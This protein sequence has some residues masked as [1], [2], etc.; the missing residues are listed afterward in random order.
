M[1]FPVNSRD[2]LQEQCVVK[3]EPFKCLVTWKAFKYPSSGFR[4]QVFYTLC[5]FGQ[6]IHLRLIENQYFVV[7]KASEHMKPSAMVHPHRC[8]PTYCLVRPPLKAV[9]IQT[10]IDW[11]LWHSPNTD[12]LH[13]FIIIISSS[14]SI[15][16]ITISIIII[17]SWAWWP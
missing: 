13:L 7:N 6:Y 17:S 8:F 9:W 2:S 15:I 11:H 14:I 4:C 16:I 3:Q 10:G 12:L 5:I 1:A